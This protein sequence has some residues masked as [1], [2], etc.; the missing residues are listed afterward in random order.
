MKNNLINWLISTGLDEQRASLY[1][2]V[3]SRGEAT[4]GELARA[5]SVGRTAVY[6]NLRVLEGRGYVHVINKGKR[7]IYIPIHPK[8]LYKKFDNQ[9]QQLK[10]LLPDF[11]ALYSESGSQPFV[12]LF[13]GPYAARE[14]YEDILAITKERYSY[15]SPSQLTLQ[16]IDLSYIKDWVHRRVKKGI[17]SRSLRVKAQDVVGESLFNDEANYLRQIR[18]LPS[19]VDLKA[20]VYIYEKNIGV[21]STI[22]E[23]TSFII[24]SADLSFNFLQIF[25]FL[26]S[27][28]MRS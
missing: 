28:S 1:L 21:I 13:Q 20:S 18:Y 25:D 6:D 5:I 12:Q 22:K 3:L 17:Q 16:V 15:F 8:E 2:A 27:V 24:H 7:K 19:Y 23:G 10:D 4:A 26:W 9:R 11:L 14:V